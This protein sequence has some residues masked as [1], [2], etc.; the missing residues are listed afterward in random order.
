MYRSIKAPNKILQ[1]LWI[2]ENMRKHLQNLYDI[3]TSNR[4]QTASHSYRRVRSQKHIVVNGNLLKRACPQPTKTHSIHLGTAI[5]FYTP[6]RIPTFKR[7]T[8]PTHTKWTQKE[9][10][11]IKDNARES[12]KTDIR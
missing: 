2:N 7:C 11:V 5:T 6:I 9:K 10:G 1:K 3:K 4:L 12:G 8:N